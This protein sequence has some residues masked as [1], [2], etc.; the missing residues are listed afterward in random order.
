MGLGANI[1]EI[2]GRKCILSMVKL[3]ARHKPGSAVYGRISAH[4][5]FAVKF[6]RGRSPRLAESVFLCVF[7]YRFCFVSVGACLLSLGSG[8]IEVGE[9]SRWRN[10][11]EM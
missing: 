10:V 1:S 4:I 6:I 8:K 11:S 5:K 3:T 7:G 9:W 2:V